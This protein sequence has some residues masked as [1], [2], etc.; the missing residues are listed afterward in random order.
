MNALKLYFSVFI[1]KFRSNLSQNVFKNVLNSFEL[2]FRLQH[3]RK[4]KKTVLRPFW[5]T[6]KLHLTTFRSTIVFFAFFDFYLEVSL[7]PNLECFQKCPELFWPLFRASTSEKK[8]RKPLRPFWPT[9]ELQLKTF[10]SKD[11]RNNK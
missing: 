6:G 7:S 9:G 8:R 2:Y 10:R 4:T 5:P 1:S 3:R 11:K